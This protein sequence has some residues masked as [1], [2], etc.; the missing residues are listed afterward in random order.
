M[1]VKMK[2]IIKINI[3]ML[4]RI[5]K[6]EIKEIVKFEGRGEVNQVLKMVFQGHLRAFCL[7]LRIRG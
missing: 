2:Y 5:F 6:S 3:Y 4:C 1:Q 7:W